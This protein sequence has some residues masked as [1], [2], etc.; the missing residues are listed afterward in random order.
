MGAIDDYKSRHAERER[1][2][3]DIKAKVGFGKKTFRNPD[4]MVRFTWWVAAFT[5]CL[6]CVGLIQAW[7]FIQSERAFLSV[8]GFQ[9]EGG[10]TANKP[11][12][13]LFGIKNSGRSAAT[14]SGLD[15]ATGSAV[16]WPPPDKLSSLAINAIPAGDVQYEI[17][18]PR[19]GSG[20][21]VVFPE[22]M[23]SLIQDGKSKIYVYGLIRFDDEFSIFWGR[24]VSF[25]YL[26]IPQRSA[27]TNT[28]FGGCTHQELAQIK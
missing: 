11:L 15:I 8:T 25:C 18:N 24:E 23:F 3:Q 10:L 16:I 2:K 26:H 12:A 28:M 6:A 13:F 21:P 7:A 20:A 4:R 1:R 17:Y 27:P 14:I 22:P 5:F 19:F 9:I